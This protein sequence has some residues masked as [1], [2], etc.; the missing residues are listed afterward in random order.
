[1]YFVSLY[2]NSDIK[3]TFICER[4]TDRKKNMGK[5]ILQTKLACSVGRMKLFIT[6]SSIVVLLWR[7]GILVLIF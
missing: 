1:M 4:Y 3:T 2:F 7:R 5:R 6:F